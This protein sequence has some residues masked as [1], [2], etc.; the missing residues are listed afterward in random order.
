MFDETLTR[1]CNQYRYT[2]E[3][4][5]LQIDKQKRIREELNRI[6]N[7]VDVFLEEEAIDLRSEEFLVFL[8]D[9]FYK[10]LKNQGVFSFL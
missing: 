9:S 3:P 7:R 10:Q 8:F 2:R 6:L 1:L 4:E 5:H